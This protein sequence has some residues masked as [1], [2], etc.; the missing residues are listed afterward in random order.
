[1]ASCLSHHV[2]FC[3]TE[4]EGR[5]PTRGLEKYDTGVFFPN[6]L[7]LISRFR[8]QIREITCA[9][10]MC[11]R[12][13]RSCSFSA[14]FSWAGHRSN[15]GLVGS[16]R[17]LDSVEDDEAWSLGD[18]FGERGRNRVL[19]LCFRE[20]AGFVKELWMLQWAFEHLFI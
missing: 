15:Q 14:G 1:M 20:D 8:H 3:L 4:P 16:S 10:D 9:L 12:A 7:S 2:A 17:V 13:T 6:S 5:C 18:F 11:T 19:N